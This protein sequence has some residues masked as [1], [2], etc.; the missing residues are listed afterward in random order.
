MLKL[1]ELNI[2]E[3]KVIGNPLF[4]WNVCKEKFGVV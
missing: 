4:L 2:V 3:N 1:K